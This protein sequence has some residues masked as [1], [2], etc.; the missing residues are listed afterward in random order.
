MTW[1]R[2]DDKFH[3]HVKIQRAKT[4]GNSV[5]G[6]YTRALSY[7]ADQLTD[8]FV[9]GWWAGTIA[10]AKLLAKVT[11]VDLWI[12][13]KKGASQTVTER[14]DSGRRRLADVEVT[15]PANGYF[16]RDYLLFNPSRAEVVEKRKR[17][18]GAR[19]DVQQN[20]DQTQT[21]S[22]TQALKGSNV[23][24]AQPRASAIDRLVE[25]C[26]DRDE[27]T[28]AQFSALALRYQ[29]SEGDFEFARECA[30]GPGVKSPVRVAYK[31]LEKRGKDK[32]A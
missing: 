11:E 18:A 2:L 22:H 5:A 15:F 21:Q 13:V 19:A 28:K 17:A 8:G 20:C 16:I 1:T 6:V 4:Q 32:V 26:S 23:S 3:S 10:N 27:G 31:T 14:R 25:A 30:L 24:A 29:L 9:D 12:E 7:C